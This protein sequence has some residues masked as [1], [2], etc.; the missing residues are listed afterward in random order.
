VAEAMRRLERPIGKLLGPAPD[1]SESRRTDLDPSFANEGSDLTPNQRSDFRNLAEHD[2]A[3]VR[4]L[5]Y[6]PTAA[7]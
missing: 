1:P 7:T 4:E 5:A 6:L 3:Q 2:D